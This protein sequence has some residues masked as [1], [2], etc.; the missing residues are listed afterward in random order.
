[1]YYEY[2][3]CCCIHSPSEEN[4]FEAH[5]TPLNIPQTEI[6][7]KSAIKTRHTNISLPFLL[8]ANRR[9]K[10]MPQPLSAKRFRVHYCKN[11]SC[12]WTT[13]WLMKKNDSYRQKTIIFPT[14]LHLTLSDL[15]TSGG[16]WPIGRLESSTSVIYPPVFG[17]HLDYSFG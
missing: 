3:N 14:K 8:C 12:I 9:R 11:A 10:M 4:L 15:L 16:N 6:S 13:P 2:H 1:M 17:F 5:L 7:L